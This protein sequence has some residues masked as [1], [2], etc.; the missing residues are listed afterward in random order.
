MIELLTRHGPSQWSRVIRNSKSLKKCRKQKVDNGHPRWSLHTIPRKYR[1]HFH[2]GRTP[3]GGGGG[4][5]KRSSIRRPQRST[6]CCR[7]P[8]NISYISN[9]FKSF[10]GRNFRRKSL[11]GAT[12][13]ASTADPTPGLP[14]WGAQDRPKKRPVFLGGNH[15]PCRAGGHDIHEFHSN[16]SQSLQDRSKI[17]PRGSKIGQKR[18]KTHQERAKSGQERPKSGQEPHKSGQERPKSGQERPK[19]GQ[20]RPKSGP[21]AAKS[22]PKVAKND[23]RPAQEWSRA[24]KSAPRGSKQAPRSRRVT[25]KPQN[26]G[27]TTQF[28]HPK[29][30]I[31]ATR[32]ES[33]DR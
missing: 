33:I 26:A 12:L 22:S 4:R 20:E 15:P 30:G 11:G 5:A 29:E 17:A 25:Q 23:P 19:S 13:H 31:R 24:A 14:L 32:A 27:S 6:A 1:K 2:N 28:K 8:L 16:R 21:R 18:P 10:E 7:P 9:D 3:E